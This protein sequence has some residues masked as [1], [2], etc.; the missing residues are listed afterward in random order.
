MISVCV[1]STLLMLYRRRMRETGQHRGEVWFQGRAKA[2][3]LGA[4]CVNIEG[5]VSANMA[6]TK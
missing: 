4:V 2:I 1:L 5:T 3:W 6:I